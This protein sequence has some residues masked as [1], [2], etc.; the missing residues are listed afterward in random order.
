MKSE[1]KREPRCP[2]G[3]GDA[4]EFLAA[5]LREPLLDG[6]RRAVFNAYYSNY[7][8]RWDR[9][10]Q[11]SYARQIQPL[12]DLA[13]GGL[14]KGGANRPGNRFRV[15]DLGCGCGVE[16]LWTAYSAGAEVV[17]WDLRADR[18]RTAERCLE[19]FRQ[20]TDR[21]LNV[22]YK[23]QNLFDGGRQETF[24]AVWMRQAF[25]HIEPRKEAARKIASLLRPGGYAVASEPNAWNPLIQLLYFKQ[26]GFRTIKTFRDENGAEHL[27]GNERILTPGS[28]ARAFA[29]SGIRKTRVE[30]FRLL[31][32]APWTRRF[33]ALERFA[34]SWAAPL[35]IQYTYVGQKTGQEQADS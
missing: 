24:D 29:E 25:H 21:P 35:F 9:Y 8:R 1:T 28:M 31:P 33:A 20:K 22:Q 14:A 19:I 13:E 30:Y 5:W 18:L 11:K 10:T 4:G 12:L 27:Y 15:L 7:I 26:R 23:L 2:A 32:N 34:P 16:A 3:A 6:E 17:G